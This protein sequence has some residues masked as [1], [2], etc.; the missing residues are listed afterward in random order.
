MLT[1]RTLLSATAIAARVD[2]LARLL[3]R[4]LPVADP[5]VVGLL[6][7]S[8]VFVADLVRAAARTGLEPFVDFLAVSH[9]GASTHAREA[10]AIQKDISIDIRDRSVLLVDDIVDSGVTLQAA[11][12]HLLARGPRW[13]RTCVLLDKAAR[14]SVDIA[15]DYVGFRIPD[16]WVIGYGLDARGVG[17]CLP[18]VGAVEGDA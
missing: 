4:D 18:Y 14:R 12:N 10:A 3:Q 11:R 17:R 9:Y 6:T 15:V 16:V 1:H 7:G 8:F 13:L 2:E 5:V